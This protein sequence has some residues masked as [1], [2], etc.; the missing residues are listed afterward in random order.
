MKAPSLIIDP[1]KPGLLKFT[2]LAT[3]AGEVAGGIYSVAS[4]Q[5][6]FAVE[7]LSVGDAVRAVTS[8]RVEFQSRLR[9]LRGYPFRRVLIVGERREIERGDFRQKAEPRAVLA[10][11]AALEAR[12]KIP[13]IFEPSPITAA[14][15]VERWAWWHWR[16]QAKPFISKTPSPHWA[17]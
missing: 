8:G 12:F 5:E 7:C 2:N 3:H 1:A 10:S 13:V 9:T 6:S 17:V 4:L 16:E 15:L 14:L 11:L